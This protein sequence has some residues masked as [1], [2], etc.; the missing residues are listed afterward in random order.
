[1][2]YHGRRKDHPFVCSEA[3]AGTVDADQKLSHGS[4]R[5]PFGVDQEIDGADGFSK[6]ASARTVLPF[7]SGQV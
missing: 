3:M 6:N 5:F 7:I 4:S 2:S 1:M